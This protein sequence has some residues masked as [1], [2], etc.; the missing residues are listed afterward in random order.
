VQI[1]V[2]EYKIYIEVQECKIY[3]ASGANWSAGVHV[4]LLVVQIEV[5]E[6]ML[7]CKYSFKLKQHSFLQDY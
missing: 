4:I 6:C 7:F 3:F 2:Q 5:Q 1:E